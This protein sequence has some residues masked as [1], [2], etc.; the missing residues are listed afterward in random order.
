MPELSVE[1]SIFEAYTKETGQILW[2]ESPGWIR[3]TLN[4]SAEFFDVLLVGGCFNPFEKY[5]ASQIGSYPQV[6]K[7]EKKNI[8]NHHLV[9]LVAYAT[10]P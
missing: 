10:Q 7:G 6:G 3:Q 1:V 5:A 2:K 8:W 9:G 4:L